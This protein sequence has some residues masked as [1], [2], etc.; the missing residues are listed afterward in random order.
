MSFSISTQLLHVI[1]GLDPGTNQAMM[2]FVYILASQKNG[3]TY[4]GKTN[5]LVRRVWEHKQSVTHG[6]TSDHSVKKLVYFEVFNDARLAIAREKQLKKWNRSWKVHLIEKTNPNWN[7]L[8]D[9]ICR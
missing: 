1:L 5:D 8:Y 4:V 9:T 6:F 2:R 3:T 7:D